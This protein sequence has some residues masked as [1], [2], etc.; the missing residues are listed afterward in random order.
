MVD[1]ESSI[2]DQVAEDFSAAYPNGSRYGEPT[3]TPAKFPALVIYEADEY[4]AGYTDLDAKRVVIDV[5][6]YS[7]RTSGA[8][9]E[10]KAIMELVEKRLMSIGPFKQ[11]FCN[12]IRNVDQR[13]FRMKSRFRCT[14]V[15]EKEIDGNVTVRIYKK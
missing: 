14:A 9:Q 15:Q 13:I 1:I 7:D 6:V 3:D 5:D 2:F 10:C 11:M 12:Q 8:K 4:D